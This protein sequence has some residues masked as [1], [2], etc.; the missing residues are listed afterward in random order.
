[1]VT[2]ATRRCPPLLA[3]CGLVF[4]L[5]PAGAANATGSPPNLV[6]LLMDDVSPSGAGGRGRARREGDGPGG[7]NWQLLR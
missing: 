7:C 1:M 6:V 5:S 3:L 2:M 4:G